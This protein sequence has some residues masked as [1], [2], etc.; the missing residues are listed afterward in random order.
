MKI[1]VKWPFVK[2]RLLFL[3]CKLCK[4]LVHWNVFNGS[5]TTGYEKHVEMNSSMLCNIIFVFFIAI[6]S[7]N[8]YFVF[9]IANILYKYCV[10]Y[11][12]ILKKDQPLSFGHRWH[13]SM[14]SY[15]CVVFL[16]CHWIKVIMRM[17][18]YL[19][20]MIVSWEESF[21]KNENNAKNVLYKRLLSLMYYLY[22]KWHSKSNIYIQYI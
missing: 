6:R 10:H 13:K 5:K 3:F 9:V 22:L 17:P 15:S 2:F 8:F 20:W 1:Q 16:Y 18:P 21:L 14:P 7:T 19:Q 12:D 4:H 11:D